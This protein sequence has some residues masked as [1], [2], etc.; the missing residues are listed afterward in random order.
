MADAVTVAS[1]AEL[2][3]QVEE[4]ANE[5]RR[6]HTRSRLINVRFAD[7]IRDAFRTVVN[8]WDR[9]PVEAHYWFRGAMRYFTICNDD[10]PDFRSAIGFDDDSEVLNA[11]LQMAGRDNL[12][13]NPEDYD[14]A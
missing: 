2:L 10:E 9:I 5:A 6:A 7:A 3:R 12:C 14:D 4:H 13:L 8:D 11:C 1:V